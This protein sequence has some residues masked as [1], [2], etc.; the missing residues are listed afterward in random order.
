[1]VL[2]MVICF[3]SI[4]VGE[5][6]EVRVFNVV[7]VKGMEYPKSGPNLKEGALGSIKHFFK[8]VVKGALVRKETYRGSQ[9]KRLK[10][11]FLEK[12]SENPKYKVT[13]I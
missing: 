11:R 5:F 2:R 4:S 8:E 9:K 1:M 6:I 7:F 3:G 13:S 10:N 12:T